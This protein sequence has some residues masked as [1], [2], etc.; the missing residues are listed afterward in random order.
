LKTHL[1]VIQGISRHGTVVSLNRFFSD[2]RRGRT[3]EENRAP[4]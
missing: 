1:P 4:K 3:H 2:N